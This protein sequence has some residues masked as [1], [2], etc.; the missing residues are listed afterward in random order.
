MKK[1]SVF[2]IIVLS[3]FVL[4]CSKTGKSEKFK[5]LTAHVWTAD[6]LLANKLDA[7]GPGG[8]LEKFKGNAE[9]K[10]DGTGTFGSYIGEWT[11]NKAETEITI[12][13]DSLTFPVICDIVELKTTSLKITTVV[14]DKNTLAPIN[15]RMTFK[16]K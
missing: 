8:L 4:A 2:L 9:F 7:S 1:L 13:S 10:D 5:L 11:F 6:S 15:I 14:P 16:P 3:L 12:L